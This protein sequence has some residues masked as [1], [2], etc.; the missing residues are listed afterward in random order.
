MAGE[1]SSIEVAEVHF[2]GIIIFYNLFENCC[3]N[4]GKMKKS[5]SKASSKNHKIL[6]GFWV[7]LDGLT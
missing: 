3:A 4:C 7:P 6:G 2:S 1:G 5:D